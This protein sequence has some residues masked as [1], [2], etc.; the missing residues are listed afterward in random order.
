MAVRA[1]SGTPSHG[2]TTSGTPLP[3]NMVPAHKNPRRTRILI[4][5]L[6]AF[7]FRLS[8]MSWCSGMA[9]STERT[10]TKRPA[11]GI[12]DAFQVGNL[13]A[14]RSTTGWK[15]SPDSRLTESGMPR[16]FTGKGAN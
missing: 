13:S 14:N 1:R 6:S 10:S 8:T 5:F 9:A 2:N 11:R 3:S 7:L 15:A 4:T 16:Y 12:I